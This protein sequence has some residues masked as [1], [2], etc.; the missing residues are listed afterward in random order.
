M[1]TWVLEHFPQAFFNTKKNA[2]HVRR[3]A[4]RHIEYYIYGA[5]ERRLRIEYYI[6]GAAERRSR[7]NR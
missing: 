7:Y 5:A 6:Y 1:R 4:Q 2:L 3:V